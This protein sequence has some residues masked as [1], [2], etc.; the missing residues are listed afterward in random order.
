[1]TSEAEQLPC[2]GHCWGHQRCHQ[3]LNELLQFSSSPDLTITTPAQRQ[4][5][6]HH[7]ETHPPPHAGHPGH[8]RPSDPVCRRYQGPV[9]DC[10]GC[11]RQHPDLPGDGQ[12][13]PPA[14]DDPGPGGGRGEDSPGQWQHPH[15]H[16]PSLTD[17]AGS[18]HPQ[19]Y[20]RDDRADPS[21][22][23]CLFISRFF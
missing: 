4:D 12:G 18:L 10:A 11:R 21:I 1:M 16:P 8:T 5:D 2:Q 22:L 20:I 13:W 15:Q 23:C 14:Q 7:P 9:C 3:T 6:F 19:L 17:H